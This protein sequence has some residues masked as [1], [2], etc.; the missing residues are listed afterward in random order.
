[1]SISLRLLVLPAIGLLATAA[2]APSLVAL[3]QLQPGQWTLTSREGDFPARKLCLGDPRVL[4]QVRQPV[5]ATC[6][7]FVIT[8]DPNVSTVHYTCPGSGSGRTTV[9]VETPRLAQV[10]TQ[11][12]VNGT[13]FDLTLEARRTGEC[14]AISMR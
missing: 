14:P 1:M 10:N 6:T 9:R 3:G 4:L 13:P 12:L 2:D 8:N 7:R 11:G 5:T